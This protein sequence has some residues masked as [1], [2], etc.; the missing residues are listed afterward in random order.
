[1]QAQP[2][3]VRRICKASQLPPHR[4]VHNIS[5]PNQYSVVHTVAPT[6]M[7]ADGFRAEAGLVHM[8]AQQVVWREGRKLWAAALG[9]SRVDR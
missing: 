7:T 5:M 2:Q 4:L 9:G 3:V 6:S 1:M 8:S